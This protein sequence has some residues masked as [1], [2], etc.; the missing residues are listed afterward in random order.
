MGRVNSRHA[1]PAPSS[2]PLGL[3]DSISGVRIDIKFAPGHGAIDEEQAEQSKQGGSANEPL[4]SAVHMSPG[5]ISFCHE[6]NA[7]RA[8]ALRD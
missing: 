3:L 8:G 1:R 7:V 4:Q 6:R 5:K 2:P